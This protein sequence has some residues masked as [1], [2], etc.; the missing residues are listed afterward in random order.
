MAIPARKL[1]RFSSIALAT[2]VAGGC[3]TVANTHTA[4][5]ISA[6][7]ATPVH[8]NASGLSV[9]GEELEEVSSPHF[10]VIA[11]TFE[12]P[13]SDWIQIDDVELDFGSETKNKNIFIPWG[14]QITSWELATSQR[15]AIRRVNTENALG[16]L[17]IG[18]AMAAGLGRRSA[19]GAV[20]G[21]VALGSM[22]AL[23]GQAMNNNLTAATLP[24]AHLFA[25]P[26][27]V[28]P[29]LFAKKWVLVNSAST[30]VGGCIGSVKIDY[31]VSGKGRERVWL[32]FSRGGSEWQ[33]PA[34]RGR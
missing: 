27:S 18:G 28:P 1:R 9:S 10:G 24:P 34:C 14:E 12:N 5:P 17:A 3:A 21:L 8:R 4:R 19:V 7:G 25:T 23:W 30:S 6:D 13:T 22:G 11:V 29:G 33:W 31:G 26:F 32:P 20:G 2:T 15:L 16:L